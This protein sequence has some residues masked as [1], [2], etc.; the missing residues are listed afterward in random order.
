MRAIVWIFSLFIGM[1]PALAQ[2]KAEKKPIEITGRIFT[3]YSYDATDNPT[4]SSVVDSHR[5]KRG[6]DVDRSYLQASYKYDDTWS[7]AL[8]LDVTRK[9]KTTAGQNI[10]YSVIYLRN[11]YA[12]H[13]STLFDRPA[14]ARFG[15]QSTLYPGFVEGQTKTRFL[16]RTMADEIFGTHGFPSN[17]AGVGYSFAPHEKVEVSALI[18][19]GYEQINSPGNTDNALAGDILLNVK[20]HESEEGLLKKAGLGVFNSYFQ[21]SDATASFEEIRSEAVAIYMATSDWSFVADM[22]NSKKD[23]QAQ[24]AK[25]YG[26]AISGNL[27]S[28]GVAGRYYTGNDYFRTLTGTAPKLYKNFITLAYFY[29]IIPGRLHTGLV[30]DSKTSERPNLYNDLR[31]YQW[32]WELV[33]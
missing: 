21:R 32:K 26:M 29:K 22:I 2:D 14:R 8:L 23:T 7:T 33:F 16:F 11:A 27:G 31:T 5:N 20:L 17:S 9:S 10:E 30:L 15:M 1:G 28:H 6:F 3:N 18:H 24:P 4:D 19:N 12:Q 25:G 13:A